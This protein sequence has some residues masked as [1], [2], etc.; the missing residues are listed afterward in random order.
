MNNIDQEQYELTEL[1]GCYSWEYL[2]EW[3]Q[4]MSK[5]EIESECDE[6]WPNDDNADLARRIF[7]ALEFQ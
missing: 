2:V 6:C 5:K 4:G 3:F 7:A 1:T